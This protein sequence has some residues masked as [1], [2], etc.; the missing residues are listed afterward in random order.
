MLIHLRSVAMP[1]SSRLS[2]HRDVYPVLVQSTGQE[3]LTDTKRRN[4]PSL[5]RQA[6]VSHVVCLS[7][8]SA[9]RAARDSD[10]EK[11]PTRNDVQ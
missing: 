6:P 4:I 2:V 10:D 9:I 3:T 1:T 11:T 8:I 7:S 5:P